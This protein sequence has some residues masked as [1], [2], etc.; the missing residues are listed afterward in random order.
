MHHVTVN[1]AG[2]KGGSPQRDVRNAAKEMHA[3][4]KRMEKMNKVSASKTIE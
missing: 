1:K 4:N 2:I 3:R